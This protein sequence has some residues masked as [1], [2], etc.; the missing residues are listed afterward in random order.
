MGQAPTNPEISG[1]PWGLYVDRF[2]DAIYDLG[3]RAEGGNPSPWL[4]LRYP[5]NTEIDISIYEIV[6]VSMHPLAVKDALA[7]GYI[8]SGG[9]IFPESMNPQTVPRIAAVK[10][11]AIEAM[12]EYNYQFIMATVPAVTFIITMPMAVMGSTGGGRGLNPTRRPIR[13][14]LTRVGSQFPGFSA[15]ESAIIREAQQILRSP[16]LQQL[17]A[18]HQAGQSVSVRVG[19][20]LIQYE[21][22][23]SA[24]GMTMFG[25]NGFILGRHAFLLTEN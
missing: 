7:Q 23:V 4:R 10:R 20:R 6:D 8:G 19:G 11:S 2:V 24:S 13:N 1:L 16:Q 18:A 25:E 3:Y 9:R 17:R 14:R 12:E 22:G 21:P 5:D 15:Q